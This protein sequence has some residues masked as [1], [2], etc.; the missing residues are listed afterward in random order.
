LPR[1][2]GAERRIV[3]P[4]ERHVAVAV[5]LRERRQPAEHLLPAAIERRCT[6]LAARPQEAQ[7]VERLDPLA[8]ETALL[9]QRALVDDPLGQL[10]ILRPPGRDRAIA[11]L[12]LVVAK[13]VERP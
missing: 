7:A 6:A 11:V 13:G 8:R 12:L 5:T 3:P 1:H 2:P 9:F 4:S 10:A